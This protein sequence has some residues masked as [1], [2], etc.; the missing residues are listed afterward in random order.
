MPGVLPR[1][2]ITP[3]AQSMSI[4]GAAGPRGLRDHRRFGHHA[5]RPGTH[6]PCGFVP[7]PV[8]AWLRSRLVAGPVAVHPRSR[9]RRPYA[10][11]IRQGM[12]ISIML[13]EP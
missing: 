10:I 3:Q 4:R 11:S 1:D 12:S 8:A 2:I 9:L 13:C 6:V 7:G 5:T